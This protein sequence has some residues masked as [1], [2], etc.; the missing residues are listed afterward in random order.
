MSQH[1][2]KLILTQK[3]SPHLVAVQGLFTMS[4]TRTLGSNG[5][6][7]DSPHGLSRLDEWLTRLPVSIPRMEVA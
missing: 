6:R 7:T 3:N 5:S 1:L 4:G 2:Q